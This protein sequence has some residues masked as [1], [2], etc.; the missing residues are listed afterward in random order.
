MGL[1]KSPSKA[2]RWYF[3]IFIYLL[4]ICI[5]NAWILYRLDCTTLKIKNKPLKQFRLDVVQALAHA[6]KEARKGRPSSGGRDVQTIRRPLT[7]RPD[8]TTRSDS[9]A[10]WPVHTTKGR[11]R[12]CV[13]GTTRLMCEKCGSRLCLTENN[14]CFKL[15]HTTVSTMT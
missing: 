2:K 3:P 12:Y 10:H 5:V 9:Y 6:G 8:S 13:K 7:E 11:C 4:D 14:N 15:F 1:Y